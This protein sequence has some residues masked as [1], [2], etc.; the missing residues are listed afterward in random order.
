MQNP[1][2]TSELRPSVTFSSTRCLL[3]AV[4][5]GLSGCRVEL[6]LLSPDPVWT[7]EGPVERKGQLCLHLL[8]SP[9]PSLWPTLCQV[10]SDAIE[11]RNFSSA[12]PPEPVTGEKF[13]Q[14]EWGAM[15][16]SEQTQTSM[17]FSL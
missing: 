10:F 7:E 9:S 8:C 3:G 6:C 12:V 4:A 13:P 1:Y 15:F 14:E 11:D 16:S 5:P 17:Y 2:W